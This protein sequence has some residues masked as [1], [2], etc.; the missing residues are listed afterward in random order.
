MSLVV[1]GE[2][3]FSRRF[4]ESA[5]KSGVEA[6]ERHVRG[7]S[8]VL[9]FCLSQDAVNSSFPDPELSGDDRSGG[10]FGG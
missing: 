3:C 5:K 7:Q 8:W 2:A 9:R 6:V 4:Y 1:F 10:A